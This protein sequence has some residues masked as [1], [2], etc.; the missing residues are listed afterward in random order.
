MSLTAPGSITLPL[1]P[2][3][4]NTANGVALIHSMLVRDLDIFPARRR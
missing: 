2:G 4:V 3:L 1:V